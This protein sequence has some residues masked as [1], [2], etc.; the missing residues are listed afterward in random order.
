[1]LLVSEWGFPLFSLF[2]LLLYA[3]DQ[4]ISKRN[5]GH[6]EL[7]IKPVGIASNADGIFSLAGLETGNECMVCP[8]PVPDPDP[9]PSRL[10][11]KVHLV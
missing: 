2:Q 3:P 5:A 8:G 4:Y 6:H 11:A 7:F 1:M 9:A 10:F